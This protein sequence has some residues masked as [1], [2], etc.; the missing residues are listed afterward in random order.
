MG[1]I[2]HVTPYLILGRNI[3]Q[4]LHSPLPKEFLLMG[5]LVLFLLLERLVLLIWLLY[6]FRDLPLD[7]QY[8]CIQSPWFKMS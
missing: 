1:N 3:W 6:P 4:Q 7:F 5:I 8:G 2:L